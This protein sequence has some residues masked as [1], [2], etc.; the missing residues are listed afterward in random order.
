[1]RIDARRKNASALRLRFSQSFASR[2]RS[3]RFVNKHAPWPSCQII[4]IRSLP[5]PLKT[6]RCKRCELPRP[7]G[8]YDRVLK[9][10]GIQYCRISSTTAG[11]S[12]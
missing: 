5:R 10:V 2:R 12:L 3:S 11:M 4:F 6:K 9:R 8:G 7:P 1:M